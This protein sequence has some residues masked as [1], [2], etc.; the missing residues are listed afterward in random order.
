[1]ARPLAEIAVTEV[2]STM[3]WAPGAAAAV[4]ISDPAMAAVVM[5]AR[6]ADVCH[7]RL[8]GEVMFGPPWVPAVIPFRTPPGRGR[9]LARKTYLFCG[10]ER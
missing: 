8:I 9:P 6:A 2:L 4:A 1:V 10:H 7:L 3:R 5:N